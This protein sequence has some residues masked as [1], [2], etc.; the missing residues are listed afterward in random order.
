MQAFVSKFSSLPFSPLERKV[1]DNLAQCEHLLFDPA[2]KQAFLLPLFHFLQKDRLRVFLPMGSLAA[3]D[4]GSAAAS[5]AATSCHAHIPAP[6]FVQAAGKNAYK[7]WVICTEGLETIEA[8]R[9]QKSEDGSPLY[10]ENDIQR[11][12][13]RYGKTWWKLP[14]Q[15]Y[16]GLVRSIESV[17]GSSASSSSG[18][19]VDSFVL[20]KAIHKKTIEDK[21]SKDDITMLVPETISVVT[22]RG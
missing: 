3:P 17:W 6:S 16:E 1:F 11:L 13:D 8:M 4:V 21:F 22:A 7:Y 2:M 20:L 9:K 14:K 5:S 12:T 19:V 15:E 18:A 10:S